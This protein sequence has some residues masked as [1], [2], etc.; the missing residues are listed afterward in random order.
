MLSDG[1]VDDY[2]LKVNAKG[3]HFSASVSARFADYHGEEVIVTN[4]VDLTEQVKAQA[5]IQQVLEACPVPLQM[6]IAET[7]EALFS[8]PETLALLGTSRDVTSYYVNPADRVSYLEELRRTGSVKNRKHEYFN[9]EGKRFM[10]AISSVLI[11]FDGQEV[12]VSSARD[13]TEEIALQEELAAQR[14]MLFQ[15]EKMSALGELL[16]GVAHELNNPLSIIVGHSLML[17]DEIESPEILRRIEKISNAAERSAKIVKTF[18]A[19]AR[20]Q[21]A[22]ME[23]VDVRSIIDTALD[24]AG[25]GHTTSN[26]RITSDSAD[27][28]VDILADSDQI[29]QVII[30]LVINAAHAIA[31]SCTGDEIVVASTLSQTEGYVEISVADNGP[32]VD[33]NIQARVFEPFFTT[34]D[35]GDG[36]GIGLAFC[37]RIIHSHGGRIWLDTNYKDGSRF[38]FT[39]PAAGNRA[40]PPIENALSEI[41]AET[42]RALIVDDEVD[43]AE[44]ISEVLTRDGFVV[45]IAHSGAQAIAHLGQHSYDILLSDLKMPG[46]DGRALYEY[47]VGNVPALAE[48]TGFITGDTMG[49]SSQ[50]LL[51][52]SQ[53]PYL[54]KPVSP[55]EIRELVQRLLAGMK[56]DF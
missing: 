18:L 20:Q 9:A 46:V 40:S 29:T 53:R 28:L 45:D 25:Y 11:E 56:E 35:V 17:R 48:R 22:K 49:G 31:S 42:K 23:R 15:N 13:L 7:G 47:L 5:L 26:L 38:C 43:V 55:G 34:K 1:Q 16:A 30:N 4:V 24:V 41:A 44:L 3:R 19:M 33:K 2:R 50:A 37:H 52:D 54:E 27:D 21:P 6:N 12:I 10:G 51:K 32:G 39:L 14:E 36:T 8:S